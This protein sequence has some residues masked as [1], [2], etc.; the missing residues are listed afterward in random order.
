MTTYVHLK[1]ILVVDDSESIRL[2]LASILETLG[3]KIFEAS[4]GEVAIEILKATP[5]D[6]LITDFRMPRLDGV[7]LLN[8][9]RKNGI[10]IPVIFL[11]GNADLLKPEE[12]ALDDC[13]ATLMFKPFQ[14]EL[15]VAALGAAD[16]RVHHKDCIHER[17]GPAN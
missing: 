8:W 13:C 11:S 17:K 7:G 4:N 3:F 15:L 16:A 2:T 6:L 1:N 12:V 14:L 10:H 5:I 9:C